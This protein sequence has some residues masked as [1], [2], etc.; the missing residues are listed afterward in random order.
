VGAG[1]RGRDETPRAGALERFFSTKGPGRLGLGLP[2]AQAI[3]AR[4]HGTLQIE[5]APE[6]GTTV[7]FSLPTVASGRRPV[8]ATTPV[9]RV[10]VI[11]DEPPVRH[12][13]V[14]AL[15]HHAPISTLSPTPP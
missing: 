9:A 5:S 4:H 1:G 14:S 2:V 12:P 15:P 6:V 8:G 7:R 13:L 3:V 11:G 10:L